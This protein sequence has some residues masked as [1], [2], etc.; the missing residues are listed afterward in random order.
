MFVDKQELKI[1]FYFDGILDLGHHI[2]TLRDAF[3][4]VGGG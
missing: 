4:G 3:N 1:K 2:D